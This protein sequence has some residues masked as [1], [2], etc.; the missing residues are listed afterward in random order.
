VGEE[1]IGAGVRRIEALTGPA[2][3]A[4]IENQSAT[5][6]EL[7]ARLE[8]TPDQLVERVGALQ[9]ELKAQ[10][11]RLQTLDRESTRRGAQGLL[12][13]AERVNGVSVVVGRLS[14]TNVESLREAGDWLRDRLGSAVVVL[15]AVINDRPSFVAMLTP[16]LTPTG[17]G[18]LHAGEL[19]KKVAAVAGGGGGGRPDMAQAGGKDPARLD[20]ALNVARR[21]ARE[22]LS[23]KADASPSR[24]KKAKR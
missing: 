15:G 17:K 2:A 12:E 14:A 18:V 22:A 4:Y 9:E 24:A 13:E 1:S 6:R 5:L 11:K 3:D 16:D 23:S 7:A 8:A 19:V 20:E 10:S 21:L